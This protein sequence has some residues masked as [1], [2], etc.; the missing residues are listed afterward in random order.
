MSVKLREAKLE[1]AA[2]AAAYF[3][4]QYATGKSE[5][6]AWGEQ[7]MTEG[8]GLGAYWLGQFSVDME[9][10]SHRGE[11]ARMLGVMRGYREAVRT[12][13]GGRWGV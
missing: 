3:A 2:E 11:R 6:L 9:T 12:Q 1:A 13:L 8:T 7:D 4:D 5:G 10:A